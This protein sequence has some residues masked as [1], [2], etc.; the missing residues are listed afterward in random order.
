LGSIVPIINQSVVCYL[1]ISMYLYLILNQVKK[2]FQ[3]LNK[4]GTVERV[5]IGRNTL[6]LIDHETSN[7]KWAKI[8]EETVKG[9]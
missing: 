9:L 2:A 4:F 1:I 5:L 8:V 7:R 6:P 3:F